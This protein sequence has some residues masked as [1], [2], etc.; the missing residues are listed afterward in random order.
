MTDTNHG[1]RKSNAKI[2]IFILSCQLVIQW[3]QRKYL[4][5]V[6]GSGQRACLNWNDINWLFSISYLQFGL[7]LSFINKIKW[8]DYYI[9]GLWNLLHFG[10]LGW[11]FS[12][13]ILNKHTNLAKG[14]RNRYSI[15]L[16][17]ISIWVNFLKAF[18]TQKNQH[19]ICLFLILDCDRF[20][21]KKMVFNNEILK[22]F[23]LPGMASLFLLLLIHLLL[24]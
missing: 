13:L 7:G 2:N 21:R 3:R 10:T 23:H 1:E 5:Q 12:I 18:V 16:S 11:S 6:L 15:E 4:F 17:P 9:L 14:Y 19:L 20:P 8:E 24:E 22:M